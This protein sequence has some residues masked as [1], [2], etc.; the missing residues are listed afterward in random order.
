MDS[1]ST[2]LKARAALRDK[3]SNRIG[4]TL[5]A[6]WCMLGATCDKCGVR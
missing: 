3:I 2:A 6:G 5:I 1:K 4:Q